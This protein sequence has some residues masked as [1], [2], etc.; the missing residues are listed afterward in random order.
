MKKLLL[1]LALS[2]SLAGI[3]QTETETETKTTTKNESDSFRNFYIGIGGTVQSKYNLNEK[4]SSAGLP[5]LNLTVAEFTFGWNSFQ[6]KFSGDY[7]FGFFGGR[8]DAGN[9]GNRLMG[10]NLRLRQHYNIVNKKKVAFTGGLNFVYTTNQVDVFSP[11]ATIDMNDLGASNNVLTI[12]NAMFYVGPSVALYVFRDMKFP[13]RL[14]LGYELALTRGRWK[15]DFSSINNTI[16]ENGNNRFV[17]GIT[18]L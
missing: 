7:E 8:N 1:V 17:F 13:L 16:G 14:N 2:V 4:L 5:T 18:L 15:S 9:E 10:F 11:N 12:R 3:S 6:E